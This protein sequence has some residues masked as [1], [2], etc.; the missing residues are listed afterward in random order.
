MKKPLLT[1]I[2]VLSVVNLA[3]VYKTQQRHWSLKKSHQKLWTQVSNVRKQIA[4]FLPD[5]NIHETRTEG[6]L[7]LRAYQ[8]MKDFDEVMTHHNIKYWVDFGSLLGAVRHKGIIPWDDDLDIAL[9]KEDIASVLVLKPIF[10]KL[11]YRL[12]EMFFGY[13]LIPSQPLNLNLPDQ[14]VPF[15][16]IFTISKNKD[17][18]WAYNDFP[19]NDKERYKDDDIWPLKRHSFGGITVPIPQKPHRFLDQEFGDNWA[20]WAYVE[21]AHVTEMIQEKVL[22]KLNP[23]DRLP[24]K[25]LGPLE[26]RAYLWRS[27]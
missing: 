19:L 11:G 1:L 10:E 17:G 27:E 5:H 9:K 6:E 20:D 25:P 15:L 18:L 13:K 8:M 23:A 21:S 22:R 4:N 14:Y 24:A 26:D 2:I 3:W 16:D 7:I 12:K